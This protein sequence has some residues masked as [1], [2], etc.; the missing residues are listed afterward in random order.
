M[1]LTQDYVLLSFYRAGPETLRKGIL[2]LAGLAGA[3]VFALGVVLVFAPPKMPV[4]ADYLL[5][6]PVGTV[7]RVGKV[8]YGPGPSDLQ[9]RR[10]QFD[11]R[12]AVLE[13]TGDSDCTALLGKRPQLDTPQLGVIRDNFRR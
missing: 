6:S 10:F 12:T 5:D 7:N 13:Q 2:A 8:V 9:C 4:H 1:K 3:I 11:N